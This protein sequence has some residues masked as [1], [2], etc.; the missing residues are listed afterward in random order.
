ML[1]VVG[2]ASAASR[3]QVEA[4][5][6]AS[7]MIKIEIPPEVLLAGAGL[8][9]WR[10]YLLRLG[11]ALDAGRDV[12]LLPG[13]ESRLDPGKGCMLTAALGE[14]TRPFAE[15]VG[16]LVSTGGETARAILEAW[17]ITGL[18][19]M[20][21]VETGVPW[22]VTE[23]WHRL[24]PVVTKA[25]S[26]GGPRTLVDCRKFLGELDCGGAPTKGL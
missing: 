23:G 7:D 24:L 26:F 12:V 13:T 8:P 15:R 11:Q 22:A 2:S 18:W 6:A 1:F 9:A 4:L 19:L 21:E 25:G 16:A 14:M 20:G 10:E 17:G 3:D 5:T